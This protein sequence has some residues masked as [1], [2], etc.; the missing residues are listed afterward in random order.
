MHSR[1]LKKTIYKIYPVKFDLKKD[2]V[3][4][5]SINVKVSKTWKIEEKSDM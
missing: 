3:Y 5:Q 4:E 1:S 2:L